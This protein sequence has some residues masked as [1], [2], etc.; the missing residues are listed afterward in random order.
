[1]WVLTVAWV[2]AAR[3]PV[4]L[5]VGAVPAGRARREAGGS[6]RRTVRDRQRSERD[7]ERVVREATLAGAVV[8]V[9]RR[10]TEPTRVTWSDGSVWFYY[11]DDDAYREATA[12]GMAP[13]GTTRRGEAPALGE[14]RPA[15]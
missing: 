5:G 1:M 7:L 15:P 9:A 4:G 10:G 3:R 12:R 14:P 13:A 6:R 11:R 2:A 8:A